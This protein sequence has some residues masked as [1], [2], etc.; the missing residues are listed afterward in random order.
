MPRPKRKATENK[1]YDE[2]LE[3]YN[4]ESKRPKQADAGSLGPGDSGSNG[5]RKYTKSSDK[6]ST[7]KSTTDKKPSPGTQN[8]KKNGVGRPKTKNQG[9]GPN[10]DGTGPQLTTGSN[11]RQLNPNAPPG[12]RIPANWQPPPKPIDYFSNKINLTGAY[13]DLT[14]KLLVC[15]NQQFLP[16]DYSET[17]KRRKNFTLRKG[18]FIYMI[19]EPPGE[20]YYI[21]RI[22]GFKSK[23]NKDKLGE[24]PETAT[25]EHIITDV[26]N[27]EFQI[28]W[29]YRPRDISKFSVDSRVLFAS[30]HTDTCPLNSFRG[31][32]IVKHRQDI[33]N[34]D[35]Y[36]R[37][38]NRF[39]FDK[40]YDRYMI[41]FYD[42]LSTKYLMEISQNNKSQN[43]L[44]ALNKRFEFIFVETPMTKF[45]ING[46]KSNSCTCEI[47]GQWCST[48]DS[49]DCVNC[50]KFYHM[51]CLDPPLLKKPSRGFSWTC[52]ACTKIH[53]RQYKN[54]KMFM[55]SHDNKLSNEKELS[56]EE[57]PNEANDND[58]TS[59]PSNEEDEEEDVVKDLTDV[60]PKYELMAME[61]LKTDKLSFEDRRLKEEWCMRY[62]GMHSKLED[63]VDLEDRSPYP[64]ASTR[65]GA[66]H[67]AHHIPQYIDH[68]IVY[69]D[70]KKESGRGPGKKSKVQAKTENLKPLPVPK[71]YEELDPKEYPQW[72]QPRPKGYIERGVDD[73]EGETCTLLWKPSPEDVNDGFANLD[74]YIEQCKPLAETLD[75]SPNSPNFMD[76]IVFNYMKHNGDIPKAVD[77]SLA[78]TK[79][80]LNEP[81]L[82]PTQIKQFEDG[83]RKYGS[84][85]YPIYKLMKGVKCSDIVRFYYLWKKTK[86]GRLIWGNFEGRLKKKFQNIQNESKD[87]Q[88][89]L[90]LFTHEDDSSYDNT[91][92]SSKEFVCKH[93]ETTTSLQWF[94]LAGHDTNVTT[95][96]ENKKIHITGLCFRC[97]KMWRRYATVWEDPIEIDRKIT[98]N[99]KKKIEAE[100]LRDAE[101]I[102]MRADESGGL[103]SDDKRREY[104]KK[105][106]PS[107]SESEADTKPKKKLETK[108][109]EETKRKSESIPAGTKKAKTETKPKPKKESEKKIKPEPEPEPPRKPYEVE[110]VINPLP[111]K[112][113]L[114]PKEMNL[115][116]NPAE[117]LPVNEN[118]LQDLMTTFK[119]KM[120]C[121]LSN[122]VHQVDTTPAEDP[123]PS[124]G[125]GICKQQEQAGDMLGCGKCGLSVHSSC[126]GINFPLG[127]KAI[128]EWLCE[129]C[130]NEINPTF[131]YNNYTCC[132]CDQT[133]GY[134]KP[135][136]ES[137][138]WC[139]LLCAISNANY[140]DFKIFNA[141]NQQNLKTI[142]NSVKDDKVTLKL[143]IENISSNLEIKSV[144]KLFVHSNNV[145]QVCRKSGALVKCV[146]PECSKYYHMTCS[147]DNK[148]G[149]QLTES[150][151][152]VRI[153]TKSGKLEPGALCSDH[154]HDNFYGFRDVG[155]KNQTSKEEL[156]LIQL[157][158]DEL[159]KSNTHNKLSGGQSRA[160]NYIHMVKEVIEREETQTEPKPPAPCVTCHTTVSPIW[161]QKDQGH[162]C[163]RCFH[164]EKNEDSS[165]EELV[166]FPNDF[167]SLSDEP[168]PGPYFGIHDEND[169][170]SSIRAPLQFAPSPTI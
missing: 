170:L 36:V 73:G 70:G 146:E 137:G 135:I 169:K 48:Q 62:L 41:K 139:H 113:Y 54:N 6:S 3:L 24:S 115:I 38:P 151:S 131:R 164:N 165:S 120:L 145:C 16:M 91:P 129:C 123:T 27:M 96:E 83:V 40:L 5:K 82:T 64:R 160:F 132:L 141:V 2:T 39:Y 67:Q 10:S 125:C 95:N 163:Q 116:L 30:M 136:Y 100:L 152:K 22:L 133:G 157:Y 140:I 101:A 31:V 97:A 79:K 90:H 29:Y 104:K 112:N 80:S 87:S 168:L 94:R 18:D 108:K 143:L 35:D 106:S 161:R 44:T 4:Q 109:T 84:E 128:L 51:T 144:D 88:S 23:K 71:E 103:L 138:D 167:S 37:L 53:L 117:K 66:K 111:H 17:F 14:Q 89:K 110:N 130:T 56:D 98:K 159:I 127:K 52:E 43:F 76:K 81:E 72:L 99:M 58:D 147:G 47:C 33:D 57:N 19:S 9:L 154:S 65:I 114:A 92:N 77:E 122:L 134:L 118:S 105:V 142:L 158:I 119:T 126:I 28:Q 74:N 162:I 124:P 75:M 148:V 150:E 166:S 153:G 85:L 69:Y 68:P 156:P 45:L 121:D 102:L 20:P 55:L 63:A 93:C 8:G 86:N 21:G 60:L 61:F 11:N 25:D 46:F 32:A 50:T 15:P 149:F 1:S 12:D 34:L 13:I 26:L 155:K 49:V 42:I 7:D 78:I 59:N 107:P